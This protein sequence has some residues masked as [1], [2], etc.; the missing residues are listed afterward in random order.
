MKAPVLVH[1]LAQVEGFS[2]LVLLGVA[3]PLKYAFA[4]PAAVQVVGWIHGLL[5]V[6]L[7]AAL[8]YALS[9]ARWPMSRAALVFA[10]SL[11]PLGPFLID[12]RLREYRG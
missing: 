12:R 5:F 8:L 7:C 6:A 10:A 9:A 1:R 11:I 4:M 3:M 2:F